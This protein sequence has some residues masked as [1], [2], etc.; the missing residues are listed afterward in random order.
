MDATLREAY[1]IAFDREPDTDTEDWQLAEAILSRFTVPKLGEN[2]AKRCVLKIINHVAFPDPE[3]T[4]QVITR[5]VGF[6]TE[7][8]DDL[9]S[10][11]STEDLARKEYLEDY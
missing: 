3:R 2:L 5:A 11:P 10:E 7:L 9:P 4:Q 8:W 6:A 1:K